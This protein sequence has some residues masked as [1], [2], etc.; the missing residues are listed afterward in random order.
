MI[1]VKLLFNL[2]VKKNIN[3]TLYNHPPLFTVDDSKRL[4][5]KIDGAHTK[6]LFLKNKKNNFY[7]FSC[8]E[9][10]KINLKILKEKLNLGN[11][12]FAGEKYLHE[13]LNV[14]PGAVTPFG[15]LNDSTRKIKF[16]LDLKLND[17]DSFNFH[18]LVNT[19]TI[20]IKRNDFYNFLKINGITINLFSFETYNTYDIKEY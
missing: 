12:S 20:N 3:Y 9:S 2:L 5:G 6:N 19:A 4:R 13:L 14:K 8:L 10:T 18:P 7:L 16:F 17:F 11:I 15:L 1:D